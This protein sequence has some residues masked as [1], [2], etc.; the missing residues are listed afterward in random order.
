MKKLAALLLAATALTAFAESNSVVRSQ[1]V[2]GRAKHG[3]GGSLIEKNPKNFEA[4][5]ALALALSRRARETSDVKLLR[6]SG[7]CAAEVVRDLVG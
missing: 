1:T 6:R 7:R 5:N 3:A 4:Y 2:A